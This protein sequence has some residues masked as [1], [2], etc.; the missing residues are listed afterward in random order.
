MLELNFMFKSLWEKKKTYH[1]G[2]PLNSA[3]SN[4][5]CTYIAF[6]YLFTQKNT[7]NYPHKQ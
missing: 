1:D 2:V 5:K 7:V 3:P 6:N 4:L